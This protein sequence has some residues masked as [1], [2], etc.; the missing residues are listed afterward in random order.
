MRTHLCRSCK[1]T[2][3]MHSAGLLPSIRRFVIVLGLL[4]SPFTYKS[5]IFIGA[6]AV[7]IG[8]LPVITKFLTRVYG[9]RTAA[10]RTKW[11]IAILLGLGT[12]AY[13]SGSEAVLPAYVVGIVLAEFASAEHQWLRRLR[14]L[15]T[16]FLTPFYFIRAG[17]LVSIPALIAAPVV[18]LMLFLA[19]V[20]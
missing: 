15:T 3:P 10:I 5:I 13:W 16:G 18:F 14:T 11:I 12:L 9:N 2:R 6:S 8:S 20:F 7:V 19:K 1:E 4:F 17:S